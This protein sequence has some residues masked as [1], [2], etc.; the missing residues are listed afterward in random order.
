MF[1]KPKGPYCQSCSMPLS[2]DAQ[3]GGTEL[4]GSKSCSYCS[5]CYQQGAFT[6]P[7]MTV[8][9]M[10]DKVKEKLSGMYIP[11]FLSGFFTKDIPQL[12]RWQKSSQQNCGCECKE[13][14]T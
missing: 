13:K 9:E 6:D 10:Q 14:C 2:K 11:S 1:F 12:K 5:H 7:E 8:S 3:G 4:D